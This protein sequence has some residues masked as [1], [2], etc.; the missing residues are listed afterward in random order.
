MSQEKK[1]WALLEGGVQRDCMRGPLVAKENV[2]MKRRAGRA[3][4]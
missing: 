4:Q 2:E 1:G 3:F